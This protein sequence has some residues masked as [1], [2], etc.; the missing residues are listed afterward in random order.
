MIQ[1]ELEVYKLGESEKMTV[2]M[3]G[4]SKQNFAFVMAMITSSLVS[5][6]RN[7]N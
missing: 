7:L 3:N 6:V 1:E 5:S 2:K 4:L